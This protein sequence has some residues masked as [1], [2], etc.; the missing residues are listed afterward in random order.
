MTPAGTIH[1]NLVLERASGLLLE[2]QQIS[3][4]EIEALLS[5]EG[6]ESDDTTVENVLAFLSKRF[7][8]ERVTRKTSSYPILTWE[9]YLQ[10]PMP[11][12]PAHH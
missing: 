11:T 8:A 3:Y 10:I 1:D 12:S 6:C 9:P 5:L 4:T 2:N 7:N